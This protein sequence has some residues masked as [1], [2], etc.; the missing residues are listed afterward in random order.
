M[1]LSR[2]S[3]VLVE[4]GFIDTHIEGHLI[5]S[6][7]VK[8][9]REF[10]RSIGRS[11]WAG[12]QYPLAYMGVMAPLTEAAGYS[13]L[14]QSSGACAEALGYIPEA[15]PAIIDPLE[16]G[17]TE[18]KMVGFGTSRQEKLNR[19]VAEWEDWPMQIHSCG[20]GEGGSECL[21]CS[22]C[23]RNV[24]GLYTA[25]ASPE[26]YGYPVDKSTDDRIRSKFSD[27]HIFVSPVEMEMLVNIQDHMDRESFSG[28]DDVFDIVS[29]TKIQ[30]TQRDTETLRYKIW[31]SLPHPVDNLVYSA[32][33]TVRY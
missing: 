15:T 2:V 22:K 29:S 8:M 6:R 5:N 19:I 23:I 24:L 20:R 26:F 21:S 32:W 13:P 3:R 18:C 17:N 12:V 31:Q 25:G 11:W 14:I 27:S 9:E 30:T 10:L 28:P 7:R 33:D 4:T 1:Q 16:W